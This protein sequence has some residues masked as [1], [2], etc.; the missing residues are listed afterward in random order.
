MNNNT[1]SSVVNKFFGSLSTLGFQI[2]HS[3]EMSA[4]VYEIILKT[5]V[6]V[7]KICLDS[8]EG[9]QKT[10]AAHII[11]V[12]SLKNKKNN[13]P[14]HFLPSGFLESFLYLGDQNSHLGTM[15]HPNNLYFVHETNWV[16]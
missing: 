9:G 13:Q 10:T 14:P 5:S 7:K 2:K 16:S 6:A 4:I 1:L 15:L 8:P 11:T 12:D 3:I